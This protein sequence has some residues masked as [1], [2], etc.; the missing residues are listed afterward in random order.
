M[1][2]Q[3]IGLLLS[4]MAHSW[5]SQVWDV[6]AKATRRPIGNL[7]FHTFS[8]PSN[9]NHHLSPEAF[10]SSPTFTRSRGMSLRSLLI[11]QTGPNWSPFS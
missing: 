1:L 3:Y 10:S 11:L 8:G 5:M 7:F 9:S 6:V 4:C 2:I